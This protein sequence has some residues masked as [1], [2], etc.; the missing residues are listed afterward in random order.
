MLDMATREELR[1]AI[2][3]LDDERVAKARIVVEDE[4]Q[5]ETANKAI[6]EPTCSVLSSDY[7]DRL[8][9]SL[10]QPDEPIATLTRT[11]ARERQNPRFRRA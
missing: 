4:G 3:A 2:D 9:R 6:D 5:P 11:A 7:F 10:D 8:L 1:N